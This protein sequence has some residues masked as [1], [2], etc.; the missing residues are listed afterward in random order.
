MDTYFPLTQDD[1]VG[2]H[3]ESAVV[4]VVELRHHFIL[5]ISA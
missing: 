1:A 4:L 5:L 3:P 2:Q